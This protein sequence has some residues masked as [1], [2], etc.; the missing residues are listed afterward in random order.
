MHLK[1]IYVFVLVQVCSRILIGQQR[2]EPMRFVLKYNEYLC[3]R[4]VEKIFPMRRDFEQSKSQPVLQISRDN[5]GEALSQI[6]SWPLAYHSRSK[7]LDRGFAREVSVLS[8][9]CLHLARSA[10]SDTD[11]HE[12][13]SPY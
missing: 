5:G 9:D 10:I 8:Q 7:P 11:N 13:L 2:F 3:R 12:N 6:L 1:H 4:R